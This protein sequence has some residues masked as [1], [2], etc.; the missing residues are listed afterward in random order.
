MNIYLQLSSG[1]LP[2]LHLSY[3]VSAQVFP[4]HF[5]KSSLIGFIC[6]H[7]SKRFIIT[8]TSLN[9][10]EVILSREGLF[11]QCNT[12]L[13]LLLRFSGDLYQKKKSFL[14]SHLTFISYGVSLPLYQ[15]FLL[16]TSFLMEGSYPPLFGHSQMLM[17][18][19]SEVFKRKGT[20]SHFP[21]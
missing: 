8:S 10:L 17:T 5:V 13:V 12:F 6:I 1:T 3:Y 20:P 18:S 16:Y 19:N 11:V 15:L 14:K 9:K 4:I 2:L 21:R 7:L